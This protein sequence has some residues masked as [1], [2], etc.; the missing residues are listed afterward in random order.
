MQ[1]KVIFALVGLALGIGAAGW[2]VLMPASQQGVP[3]VIARSVAT[4]VPARAAQWPA[5]GLVQEQEPAAIRPLPLAAQVE[6]LIATHDP[7]DA[8]AAYWLIAN[9]ETFNREHD[10]LV[11]D[12]EEIRQQRNIIPYRAMNDS[13]KQHDAS[14]CAG[15]T[16]RMRRSR[17][18][19]LAT[20]VQAG[21]SGALVQMASEGP[22]GDSSALTTRPEDLLVQQWKADVREQLA[23]AAESGDLQTLNYLWVHAL[24]GD[25]LIAKDPALAYRYAVAMGLI[26]GETNGPDAAEAVMYA[27]EGQ[28][29]KA[30]V[31]LSAEQRAMEAAAAQRIAANARARR[32]HSAGQP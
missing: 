22:F 14:L 20:A 32:Q 6:Q 31:Q 28:M 2:Y 1:G 29:M 15:M 11:F 7:E 9:C 25:A 18:D 13:E 23:K 8:Y 3:A 24:T 4:H 12:M 5:S 19:Y 10:R 30:I 26:E 16:E 21:V 17:F 27:P